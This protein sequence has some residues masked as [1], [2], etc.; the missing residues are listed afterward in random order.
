MP[1]YD[2]TGPGGQGA[3]TGRGLGRCAGSAGAFGFGAGRAR[4]RWGLRQGGRG[5]GPGR[6][7]FGGSPAD[8]AST[9]V[10]AGDRTEL[11]LQQLQAIEDH[12]A[13][14]RKQL[15]DRSE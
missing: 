12:L 10:A 13:E 9:P 14:L 4:P 5:L 2:G 7:A 8:E 3:L 15:R 1:G 11:V 6:F